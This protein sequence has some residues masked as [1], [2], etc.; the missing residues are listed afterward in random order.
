MA[1]FKRNELKSGISYRIIV[2]VKSLRSNVQ[3]TKSMTW[4]VP[5]GL[6]E[7]EIQTQLKQIAENFEKEEKNKS[8]GLISNDNSVRLFSF[9]DRWLERVNDNKS[10]NYYIKAVQSSNLIKDYFGDIK[11]SEITPVKVQGFMDTLF[12]HKIKRHSSLLVGDLKSVLLSRLL[13]LEK[14]KELTGIKR[15]TVERAL[16]G[17]PI[18]YDNAKSI[19][20]GLKLPYS[21]YFQDI[22]S[23]KDYAKESIKKHRNILSAILASAKKFGYIED[24]YAS[25]EYLEPI[26]G[27]KEEVP[28]LNIEEARSLL[29]ALDAEP[30]PRRKIALI[31]VLLMGIR[32][33]ELAG[34]EWKD[35]DF[36]NKTMTIARTSFRE[37]GGTTYT[38]SPKTETSKRVL[39]M[40][41]KLINYLLEY[42]VWWNNRKSLLKSVWK[43]N[44]RLLLSDDGRIVCPTM[45][46]KWLHQILERANLPKITLHALR[47][48]N[49]TLQIVSGVDPKTVSVRAGHARASTTSEFY[50]HFIK[51]SDKNASSKINEIFNKG[52]MTDGNDN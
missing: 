44:D 14:V 12:K 4:K 39:S 15:G 7:Q 3:Q 49:V 29:K 24:N 28:I 5:K 34:L 35:I 45:Y 31:I 47:H 23:E 36:E 52:G 51:S 48:T 41:E 27:F 32:R 13:T 26:R 30:E 20:D 6:T 46:V 33:A 43:N 25:P 10:K 1:S 21:K 40:P 9:I 2:K 17:Y 42:K 16:A 8:L 11:I 22:I 19:C 18:R 37:K 50:A 38:K